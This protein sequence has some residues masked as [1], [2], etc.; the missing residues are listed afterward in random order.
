MFA[1]NVKAKKE[2]RGVLKPEKSPYYGR[3][4]EKIKHQ[5]L[6][7]KLLAADLFI[8]LSLIACCGFPGALT[9]HLPRTNHPTHPRASRPLQ[10]AAPP[11]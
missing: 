3:Y 11:C 1:S 10:A 2:K 9:R 5:T 6:L 8:L 7:T 4:A